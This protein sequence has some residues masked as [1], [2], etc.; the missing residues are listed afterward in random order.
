M[1]PGL[2][3]LMNTFDEQT[4]KENEIFNDTPKPNN[5]PQVLR[6]YTGVSKDPERR[7]NRFLSIDSQ[8]YDLNGDLITPSHPDYKPEK[9]GLT[10]D[11]WL[12]DQQAFQ[13]GYTNSPPP[14]PEPQE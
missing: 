13:D 10:R 6:G 4:R 12:R 8:G 2:S 14:G 1:I 9:R 11:E 3:I 7:Q 5:T